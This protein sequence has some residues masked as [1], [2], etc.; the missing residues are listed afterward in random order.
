MTS[1]ER[2]RK[3]ISFERPDHTPRDFSA[4][5]EIW[6]RLQEHFGVANRQ[7]V[8]QRLAVD[9]RI[10]SYDSFCHH[11]DE[12]LASLDDEDLA[13]LDMEA[14]SERSSTGRMWRRLEP[15][16]SNR[17]IWGAHRRRVQTE[18]C[19]L[20]EFASFPLANATSVDDLCQWRWP[21]PEWWDFSDIEQTMAKLNAD[22]EHSIRYRVGSV[23]E[24]AWSLYGFERL[25]MDLS[26]NPAMPEY[27]MERITEVHIE[28]LRRVLERAANLI[29][30]V[31]FY[32]DL[33]SQAGLLFSPAMYARCVQPFHRRIIETAHKYGKPVM[34][35]SCGAVFGMIPSLIDSGIRILNPIQPK[36]RG[37]EPE[38]LAREFG[39]QIA[40]HGG[41]DVQELL[42]HGTPT[43]VCQAVRRTAE[44]LSRDGGYICAGSHH[45]QAD[46]PLENILAMFG[47]E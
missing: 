46:T 30:I 28:N 40:F 8:L 9:C 27:V 35:H 25:L 13:S 22:E 7:T 12:D 1:R 2:V 3:A 45:V 21:Q 23:F 33:A 17:D 37:M 34:M 26:A 10:I 44:V 29:D 39:G 20:D 43:Q 38:R 14:S 31:Y 32:D 19:V 47:V 15:D 24:T 4:V 42:P 41:I 18:F 6:R 5:P 36:A 16:G 11:P